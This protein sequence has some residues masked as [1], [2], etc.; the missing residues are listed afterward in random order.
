MIGIEAHRLHL[1]MKTLFT[2]F[3]RMAVFASLV[4]TPFLAS[5]QVLPSTGSS[6][7]GTTGSGTA[8]GGRTGSSQTSPQAVAPGGGSQPPIQPVNGGIQTT[9]PSAQP[10]GTGQ[11]SGSSAQSGS[12]AQG[13][14]STVSQP[15]S[16]GM[17]RPSAGTQSGIS[18][19]TGAGTSVGSTVSANGTVSAFDANGFSLSGGSN[20]V[21]SNFILGPGTIF[22]DS[23]GRTIPRERITQQTPVTVY[24]DQNGSN[25]VATRVVVSES[26]TTSTSTF[27]A[28]TIREVS[29]GVLVIEQ[30][31]AST[32]PARYVNDQTTNYVDQSGQP[33]NPK[34]V[35]AG[36]PVKVY[37]TKV[38]DTLVAS[39]VE[40]QTG[41]PASGLPKPSVESSTGTTTVTEPK[42]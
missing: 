33:V 15:S 24:Y 5:A 17:A 2:D 36:T 30:A 28:G 20:G 37:Y 18:S 3:R 40:V 6:G 26:S 11:A 25:L 7:T 9:N 16:T 13:S 41:A 21:G 38:G 39:R 27:S 29:P 34:S 8:Q 1:P 12:G 31:G 4:V 22:T 42:N 14:T 35:G 19:P 23:T 32:T 10:S